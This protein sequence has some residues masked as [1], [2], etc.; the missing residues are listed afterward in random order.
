MRKSRWVWVLVL[1]WLTGCCAHPGVFQKVRDSLEMVQG[2]YGLL[3]QEDL[4]GNDALRWAV[5]SADTTLLLAGELQQKWCPDP[6][7]TEQLAL[8]AQEAKRLAQAAG[9][10]EIG[11]SRSKPGD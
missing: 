2:Y 9:I 10:G 8:Q 3:V 5:V 6:G 11:T 7:K 1:V 4:S